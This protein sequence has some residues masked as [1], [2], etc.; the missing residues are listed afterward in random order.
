MK[1]TYSQ[2]SNN[3]LENTLRRTFSEERIM[4]N[5]IYKNYPNCVKWYN[6]HYSV[7]CI[8]LT[9]I[10]IPV[11]FNSVTQSCLTLCE[12]M[13]RSTPGLPVHHQ[14]PEFNQTYVLRVG[15]A[16]QSSPRLLSLSLLALNLSQHQGLF[17]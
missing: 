13:N 15:D 11:Q 5:I 7:I 17:Q 12:P 2:K 4:Q 10:F 9:C 1:K 3:I 8:N 16:I 6:I 14:L